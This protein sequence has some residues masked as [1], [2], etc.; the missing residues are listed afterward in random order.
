MEP[1]Q[2][3]L[4]NPN[5]V[6][7]ILVFGLLLTIMALISPGTTILELMAFFTLLLAGYGIY[8]LSINTWAL[9]I[10]LVGVILFV[11][12]VRKFKHPAYLVLSIIFLIIGSVYIFPGENW[13]QPGVNP[14]LATVVSLLVGGYVWVIATKAMEV[15][16]TPPA[17]DIN[18]LVGLTGE[19]KTDIHKE[20]SVQVAG[21]LWSAQS[22]ELIQQGSMIRVIGREGFILQVEQS[23]PN[24]D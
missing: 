14:F 20:G 8:N 18:A 9:A 15:A 22:K 10:L 13:W 16:V 21:E 4:L 24:Q 2:A 23:N 11:L 7:L 6:Y 1:I 19:A 5:T 17:H 12:A 3:F